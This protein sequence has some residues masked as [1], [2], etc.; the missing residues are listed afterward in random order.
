MNGKIWF[1]ADD[2]GVTAQQAQKILACH[3]EGVLN[4]ISILPNTPSLGEA[5]E[6]LEQ[7]NPNPNGYS[8]GEI[9]FGF[10]YGI[11]QK[12]VQKGIA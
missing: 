4:S 3:R 9:L 8:A 1:H 5:L 11:L 10:F 12:L 7:A 6:I 2:F